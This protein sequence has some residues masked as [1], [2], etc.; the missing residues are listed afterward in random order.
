MNKTVNINLEGM[1]FHINEDAFEI[2][3]NYLNTLKNNFKNEEGGEEI[4]RD[5]EGRIA[6]LFSERMIKKEAISLTNVHEIIKIMGDPSQYNDE[7]EQEKS[8]E[9]QHKEED[10]RK[11]KRRKV[12]R[13][14]DGKML[15]GV[16]SGLAN[17]FD[18][19]V[20]WSRIIFFSYCL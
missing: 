19:S 12:Y 20:F 13:D 17:Y 4:L 3:K 6:E 1:V 10:L 5:I 2:M 15:G 11:G 7:I 14:E 8:Q 16:C 9:Y 18:I